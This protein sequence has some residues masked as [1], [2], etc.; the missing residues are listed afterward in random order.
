MDKNRNSLKAKLAA[1][2]FNS[3]PALTFHETP[4]VMPNPV[5]KLLRLMSRASSGCGSIPESLRPMLE[6]HPRLTN[7]N[8]PHFVWDHASMSDTLI[9][10]M[11]QQR[12]QAGLKLWERVQLIV[13]LTEKLRNTNADQAAYHGLVQTILEGTPLNQFSSDLVVKIVLV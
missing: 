4:H 1:L 3:I 7:E 13:N 6:T 2:E 12:E 11:L 9:P 10:D 8:F 5:I